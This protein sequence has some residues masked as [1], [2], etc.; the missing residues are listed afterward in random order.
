MKRLAK[1]KTLN[2]LLGVVVVA[3]G[4]SILAVATLMKS[5]TEVIRTAISGY[6]PNTISGCL[7]EKVFVLKSEK[8][9]KT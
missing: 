4:Y 2:K 7:R 3:M 1:S 9:N 5:K 8:E 6:S